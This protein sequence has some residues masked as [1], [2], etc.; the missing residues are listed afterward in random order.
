M[1]FYAFIEH[2]Y[3]SHTSCNFDTQIDQIT[4]LAFA[5]CSE[6]LTTIVIYCYI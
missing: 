1:S 4:V 2:I 3:T 6:L 5:L